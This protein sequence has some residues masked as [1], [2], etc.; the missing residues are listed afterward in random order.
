MSARLAVE[1]LAAG[2]GGTEVLHGVDL[3]LGAGESL[4]LVG[5]NGAGKSTLLNAL[6]GFADV[7]AGRIV[8]DGRDITRLEPSARL[9]QA[10]MAY[11][12]Q[13]SSIF[14]DLT[15]T[16]NLELGGYLMRSP[17]QAARA[18]Q[19][20]LE[21]DPQLA[22]RCEQPARVLSG[23][24]RRVLEISR[25][26]MMEPRLLLIDEPSIGL[27]PRAVERVFAVLRE[28]RDRQ[29]KSML[30]VEQNV[31]QG[32]QFADFGRVL[33]SGR[34]AAAGRGSELLR[35][36]AVAQLFLGE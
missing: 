21:R 26:L 5:P 4:C 20:I 24:E 34:V 12:L 32:L 28:L 3:E 9:A 19:R 10:G 23:G 33:V 15:V 35:D 1:A 27:E 36:G 2:Y 14:P 18:A 6:F 22:A 29:G 11:V 17:A 8:V 13:E 31:R 7:Y 16:Q 30:I 25:A